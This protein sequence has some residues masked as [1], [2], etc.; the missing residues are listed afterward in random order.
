MKCCDKL[1]ICSGISKKFGKVEIFNDMNIE[2]E[3]NQ[4]IGLIGENG[5]GK[6][7]FIKLISGMLLPDKGEIILFNT[8][9]KSEKDII[10]LKDK[11]SILGDANR[12]LYWNLSGKDNLY[13]FWTIK[14]GMDKKSGS[15]LI[16]GLIEK[17]NMS[18]FI[19]KKV[20]SYSKG[21]KQRLLLVVALLGYPR[22]LVMDEPLNGLDYEN[23]IILKNYINDFVKKDNGTVILTSHN[24]RF[25]N[26]V[27][28]TKFVINEKKIEKIANV[29]NGARNIT[30]YFRCLQNEKESFI[31]YKK[32]KR[33]EAVFLVEANIHDQQFYRELAVLIE[34]KSIELL[35]IV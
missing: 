12:S 26:E 5:S 3:S 14:T 16:D 28:D 6:T 25:I 29:D 11:I 32:E 9:I 10:A 1:I 24:S 15:A 19:D 21:M 34:N 23:T 27:C 4:I 22:L 31:Q 8:K 20:E 18:S 35:D 17:F 30:V 13:Y 2:I 7:S 33:E